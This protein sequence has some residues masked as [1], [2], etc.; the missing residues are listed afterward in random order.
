MVYKPYNIYIFNLYMYSLSEDEQEMHNGFDEFSMG[1]LSYGDDPFSKSGII[2]LS[3]PKTILYHESNAEN[4]INK[5]KIIE[6][7]STNVTNK[8]LEIHIKEDDE[9]DYVSNPK[10]Y[11]FDEIKQIFSYNNI[12]SKFIDIIDQHKDEPTLKEAEKDIQFIHKKRKVY[13]YENKPNEKFVKFKSGRKKKGDLTERKHGKMA[14]D[15]IIKKIKAKFIDLLIKFVNN[16]ISNVNIMKREGKIKLMKK[17]NYKKYIDNI[18]R[19]HNLNILQEPIKD[20]LSYEISS[21]FSKYP[22]NWNAKIID[23]MLEN[24][25]DYNNIKY[26]FNLKL[27]EW[28]DILLLKNKGQYDETKKQYLKYLPKLNTLLEDILEKND[29]YYLSKF[30]FYLYNYEN[31]FYNKVGR[32]GK[33]V[34]K[35][36]LLDNY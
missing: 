4:K 15:N 9:Y 16:I 7:R 29:E 24:N 2:S 5:F 6:E 28:I 21:K 1:N 13:N 19:K 22:S 11:I 32:K 30:I 26:I 27:N 20:I 34:K 14:T 17:V 18:D 3:I 31:W 33:K 36:I 23:S 35:N 10:Y 8:N 12:G 25:E